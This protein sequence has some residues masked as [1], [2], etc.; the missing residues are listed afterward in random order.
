MARNRGR[1][2]WVAPLLCAVA[3]AAQAQPLARRI[4]SVG[5]VVSNKGD[6]RFEPV[7]V[8]GWRVLDI[9]QAL[10]DGD[11]VRTGHYGG[12]GIL[13]RDETQ[14]RIHSDTDL[15]I[16]QVGQRAKGETR[17]SLERGNVWM[18][19]R[20]L[21]AGLSIDTPSA[22]VSVRGTDWSLSADDK[23]AATLVV[24]S[25]QVEFFNEFG[26][27]LV[28]RGE[29]AFAE[30]GKPPVKRFI[31]QPKDQAQWQLS[32][33]WIDLISLT[34][35]TSTALRAQGNVGDCLHRA[36][37]AFDLTDDEE[38][39]RQLA[40]TRSEGAA[41][42]RI[43][44]IDA[45]LALRD[46]RADD[47]QALLRKATPTNRREQ[48]AL[49]LAHYGALI[50]KHDYA[51][52]DAV[53]ADAEK[54]FGDFAEIAL[55]RAWRLSFHAE[56]DAALPVAQAGMQR[57]P[58]DARFPVMLAHLHMLLGDTVR[59]RQALDD[60]ARL[61]PDNAYVLHLDALYR[62]K[63]RPDAQ[64]ALAH[65]RRALEAAPHYGQLW[66]DLGLALQDIG[67]QREA[68]AAYRRAMR[69][70][71]GAS[72]FRANL[73]LLL[74]TQERMAEAETLLREVVEQHPT[75]AT[76]PEGLGLIALARGRNE[77]A[78]D[79]LL[80]AVLL[81]PGL[82]EAQTLLA[83]AY[84]RDARF[85]ATEGALDTAIRYDDNDPL[86]HLIKSLIAQDHGE[87]GKAI[88]S[89]RAALERY[90]KQGEV[91]LNGVQSSQNGNSGLASAYGN[92]G[93]SQWG[94]YLS[95]R[96]FNPYWAN[97]HFSV[98]AEVASP[99][100]R[101]G[102]LVQ[103]LLLEPTAISTAPRYVEFGPR[104]PRH[105]VIAN[106]ALNSSG[107]RLANTESLTAM[108]YVRDALPLSYFVSAA[109][110]NDPGTR[111]NADARSEQL[112]LALGA[113]PDADTGLLLRVAASRA[114]SG[115]PGSLA[116]PDGDDR[117]DA[118]SA[119]AHLGL[120]KRLGFHDELLVAA[121]ASRDHSR[122]RNADPYGSNLSPLDLSLLTEFGLEQARAF[123]RLGIVDAT[124][125][126]TLPLYV[127]GATLPG[128]TPLASTLPAQLDTNTIA[129]Q[130]TDA[131]L[132]Q[133]QLKRMLDA[134]PVQLN[135][136][137]EWAWTRRSTQL[138]RT[139]ARTQA[140]GVLVFPDPASVPA[141]Y[142]TVA[143]DLAAV[144]FPF[145]AS[146]IENSA[147]STAADGGQLYLDA[148]WPASSRWLFQGGVKAQRNELGVTRV[149]PQ[150]GAAW[151][152]S[153][154]HWLRA[155]WQRQS[156]LPVAG[157][158][159]PLT[160][161]GLS[162]PDHYLAAGATTSAT[163]LQWD[164]EWSHRLFSF[165]RF[166]RQTLDGFVMATPNPLDDVSGG[167]ATIRRATAGVNMWLGERWGVAASYR[168]LRSEMRANGSAVPLL[169]ES[170]L[171]LAA[172]WVHPAQ[173]RVNLS[174]VYTGPVQADA[175]NST[176]LPGYW[177]TNAALNWQPTPKHWSLTLSVSNL[178]DRQYRVVRD[179]AGTP[180]TVMLALE[181][182]N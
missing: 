71:P 17:L 103:G 8:P 34:G 180:R 15:R 4:E 6:E 149:N 133:L 129:S 1:A 139:A 86:P 16:R 42:G 54:Q 30:K 41:A 102:S 9:R 81:N 44:L 50:R 20:T 163:Q 83:V 137:A 82:S 100:A 118:N 125:D 7:D 126:P 113:N 177:M 159:A 27:V 170:Q 96:A 73:A 104:R 148:R 53:L 181:Y 131:R 178:F 84:Y 144:L 78:I 79:W 69:L 64:A 48:L 168:H 130:D 142:A 179:Y 154:G 18:R 49:Q 101:L 174:Q 106:A 136:G 132:H 80:K 60:A 92:L 152:A 61:D 107:G 124:T 55:A 143:P 161:L 116:N 22:T 127:L 2:R 165:V 146:S 108:G 167:A 52:A 114:K 94:D 109:H 40:C 10:A 76:G 162:V 151:A 111:A 12:L 175:A 155:A 56:L 117:S 138:A 38:A 123:H 90:L 21:P 26:R 87:A 68:E 171:S 33:G 3:V 36:Q 37:H 46:E 145:A 31:V 77:E 67:D 140:N 112:N 63:M 119:N 105:D 166:E 160:V 70:Q 47:A 147:S 120:R 66:N 99:N 128:V 156:R 45:L 164:S 89:A 57:F 115:L 134:G 62:L 173:W 182:R 169:P 153:D 121:F 176:R 28:E 32:T 91:A 11:H 58:R 13:F 43:A 88:V 141:G 110:S 5:E 65:T 35:E 157:S 122:Y 93:L 98:Q 39:Q 19:A 97:S 75:L 135:Y 24:L 14:I 59:M 150:A 95:Q 85:Q 29:T 172:S 74:I 158:F 23:G 51:G 25:G 72:E